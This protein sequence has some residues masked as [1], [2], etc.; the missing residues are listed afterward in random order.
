MSS[1]VKKEEGPSQASGESVRGKDGPFE[2][3]AF[4]DL[5][6][7]K[8]SGVLTLCGFMDMLKHLPDLT[9]RCTVHQGGS[10]W[11]ELRRLVF[12]C[13][14]FLR[15]ML[16]KTGSLSQLEV[17][18]EDFY[19][20]G[21]MSLAA[22][23]GTYMEPV[24]QSSIYEIAVQKEMGE[25]GLTWR[26]PQD[27]EQ[28]LELVDGEGNPA[29]I[30]TTYQTKGLIVS[31]KYPFLGYSVDGIITLPGD[32]AVYGP[33]KI[34][35]EI[36]CP[37]MM[38][39]NDIMHMPQIQGMM[40]LSGLSQCYYATCFASACPQIWKVDFNPEYFSQVLLPQ[41]ERAYFR[42]YLPLLLCELNGWEPPF[43]AQQALETLADKKASKKGGSIG[44]DF[45]NAR[46]PLDLARREKIASYFKSEPM[47][48]DEKE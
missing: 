18:V 3:R 44:M 13:S 7:D 27:P 34:L 35:V 19:N 11:K 26:V 32:P 24:F 10:T 20:T 5:F 12:T 47:D 8:Q 17:L 2:V 31:E 45:S 39:Y 22:D 14:R 6:R 23:L 41:L 33:R 36:K 37:F 40:A 42:L 46:P 4:I 9:T 15:I 30:E 38:P 21:E 28:P 29:E 43:E 16:Q 48:V 1:V 25:R